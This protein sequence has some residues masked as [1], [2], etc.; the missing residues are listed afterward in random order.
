[1][2]SV[3]D[4]E[5]LLGK[6][7]KKRI[8]VVGPLFQSFINGNTQNF[9]VRGGSLKAVPLVVSGTAALRVVND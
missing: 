7:R 4:F 6:K 2:F 8:E 3:F 5:A 9:T 1:M